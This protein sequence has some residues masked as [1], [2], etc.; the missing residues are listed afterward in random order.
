LN[1]LNL[2]KAYI[3]S[4]NFRQSCK[5]WKSLLSQYLDNEC[6][7]TIPTFIGKEEATNSAQRIKVGATL[8]KNSFH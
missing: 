4:F 3:F 8:G 1:P 6:Y 7:K 5:D 2:S